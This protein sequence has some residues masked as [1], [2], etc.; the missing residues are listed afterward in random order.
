MYAK[1]NQLPSAPTYVATPVYVQ[2][3]TYVVP[4]P[5]GYGY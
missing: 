3:P 4:G 2:P 1:G 5:Y